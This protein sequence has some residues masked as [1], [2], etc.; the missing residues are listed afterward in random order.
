MLEARGKVC[1]LGCLSGLTAILAVVG[2]YV[3]DLQG[4]MQACPPLPSPHPRV[5]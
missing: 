5:R 4:W 1:G 2:D 3:N